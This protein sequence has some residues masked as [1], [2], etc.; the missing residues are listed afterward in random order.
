MTIGDF[1]FDVVLPIVPEPLLAPPAGHRW[2]L[3]WS[4]E[5]NEYGGLGTPSVERHPGWRL[6]SE[7]T[8]FFEAVAEDADDPSR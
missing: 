5:A 6:P 4:S 2:T 8:L 3:K 7:S 1:V